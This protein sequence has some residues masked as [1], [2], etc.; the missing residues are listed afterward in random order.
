MTDL[1]LA[2]GGRARLARLRTPGRPGGPPAFTVLAEPGGEDVGSAIVRLS[3]EQPAVADLGFSLRRHPP[4]HCLA[5][6]TV[7]ALTE[8]SFAR[9]AT[10][11]QLRCPLD[12]VDQAKAALGAGFRFEGVSRGVVATAWGA[13]AGGVFAR[14][15]CDSGE[16]IAPA[17]P[18]LPAGGIGDGVITLRVA[19]AADAAA[20]HLEHSNA[21]ARR[22]ALS[23]PVPEHE[24]AAQAERAALE[25][26]T[27]VRALMVI[28]D[29]ETGDVAGRVVLRPVVPPRVA[30]VG[31][32]VL[33]RFR[34]RRYLARALRIVSD[35]AF[36]EGGYTRL[37][38]GVKLGNTPSANG[39]IAAGW[40]FE[41]PRKARLRNPDGSFG[42]EQHYAIV[43]PMHR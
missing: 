39:V 10:R 2:S 15:P 24:T 25:W 22:W 23:D 40:D 43:H 20:L 11:V 3:A 41:G 31:A 13:A 28:V 5:V 6:D 42:D 37:E 33:P 38:A 27:G 12:D 1:H 29:D 21:E 4:D 8:W 30:D 36:A 18:D 14:L 26:V 35:W 34:G 19:T 7:R 16:P 17:L 32:G 9:G